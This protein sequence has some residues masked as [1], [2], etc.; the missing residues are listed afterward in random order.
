MVLISTPFQSNDCGLSG[1]K[2]VCQ[3]GANQALGKG[4]GLLL[5][6]E[7]L[8]CDLDCALFTLPAH[9]SCHGCLIARIEWLQMLGDKA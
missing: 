2:A 8:V 3:V 7:K 1:N 9:G 6:G 4:L 5:T